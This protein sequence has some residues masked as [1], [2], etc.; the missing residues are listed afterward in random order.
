M[1][2]Y[3]HAFTF[4]ACKATLVGKAVCRAR[5]GCFGLAIQ[6]YGAEQA[7]S[8]CRLRLLT[9]GER[10]NGQPPWIWRAGRITPTPVLWLLNPSCHFPPILFCSKRLRAADS[11]KQIWEMFIKIMKNNTN[12]QQITKKINKSKANLPKNIQTSKNAQP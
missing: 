12:N 9:R 6:H 7:N 5:G 4:A 10:V 1:R 11:Y 2:V 3:T 8:P